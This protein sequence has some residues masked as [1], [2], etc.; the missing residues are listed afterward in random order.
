MIT[1]QVAML[2]KDHLLSGKIIFCQARSSVRLA[3]E[4]QEAP[5]EDSISITQVIPLRRRFPSAVP[6]LS[7]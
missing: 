1:L 2:R 6:L 7:T 4:P 3:A 5:L